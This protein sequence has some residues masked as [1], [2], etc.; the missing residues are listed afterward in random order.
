M[1]ARRAQLDAGGAALWALIEGRHHPWPRLEC[2]ECGSS[3][4]A[5]DTPFLTMKR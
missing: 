1:R 4:F 3:W 5:S 2:P